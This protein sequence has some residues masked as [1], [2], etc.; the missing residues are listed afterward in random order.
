MRRPPF[1]KDKKNLAILLLSLTTIGGMGNSGKTEELNAVK[2]DIEQMTLTIEDLETQLKEVQSENETLKT[3]T[4][5][6][7]AALEAFKDENESFIQAGKA[8][9]KQEEA[10][11]EAERKAKVEA[12]Q[13]AAEEAARVEAEKAAVAQAEEAARVEAEK[14]AV[15]Q[16]TAAPAAQVG[17]ASAPVAPAED[18]YYKNCSIARASGAAPLYAGNPGYGAHLDRDGDGVA[19][20]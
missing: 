1:L 3:D 14:Q 8:A 2:S 11:V 16:Q 13:K 19:C 17:F 18:V 12:E 5:K 20:E 4:K 6:A 15:A 10:K 7:E 9:K